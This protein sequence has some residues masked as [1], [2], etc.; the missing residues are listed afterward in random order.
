MI[1]RNAA[2]LLD[3]PDRFNRLRDYAGERVK[4]AETDHEKEAAGC[5]RS[6]LVVATNMMNEHG[7]GP[8]MGAMFVSARIIED[9]A[10]NPDLPPDVKAVYSRATAILEGRE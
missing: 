7:T 9:A 10:G 2:S 8:F 1:P 5:I 6:L 4:N 3:M